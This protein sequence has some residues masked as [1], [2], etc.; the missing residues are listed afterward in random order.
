MVKIIIAASIILVFMIAAIF[1]GYDR[2]ET[3]MRDIAP[4]PVK[5]VPVHP[6]LPPANGN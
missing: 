2:A 6:T 4:T 3:T 1:A 5:L